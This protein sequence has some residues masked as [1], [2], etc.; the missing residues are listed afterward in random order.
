MQRQSG[1][2]ARRCDLA[3][4]ATPGAMM[5]GGRKAIQPGVRVKPIP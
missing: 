3:D 4:R 1:M 2:L 5:S